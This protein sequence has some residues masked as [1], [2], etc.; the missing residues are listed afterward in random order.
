MG[1]DE[2]PWER[3]ARCGPGPRR[4]GTWT[5]TP[6]LYIQDLRRIWEHVGPYDWAAPQDWMCED[7]IINGGWF[8]GQ[9]FVGTHLSVEE[10]QRR[11]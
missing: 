6:S 3:G 8:G 2:P 11:T 4:R 7:A 9:Y 5:R 1:N 10:H